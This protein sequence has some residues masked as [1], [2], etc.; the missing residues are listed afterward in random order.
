MDQQQAQN[1]FGL[2]W[3]QL[4]IVSGVVAGYSNKEI[5]ERIGFSVINVKLI[6][7]MIF[8]RLGLSTRE[9]LVRFAIKHGLPIINIPATMPD[10]DDPSLAYKSAPDTPVTRSDVVEDTRRALNLECES[11]LGGR[12]HRWDGVIG[13][14]RNLRP[15]TREHFIDMMQMS[16]RTGN[17][18]WALFMGKVV[19]ILKYLDENY[20][21]VRAIPR[22]FCGL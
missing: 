14:F 6:L 20:V 19:D 18:P 10:I 4:E 9:E 13:G 5:A 2:T 22:A 12:M 8:D 7:F 1:D 21:V 3:R 16:V 15:K 17:I 11:D